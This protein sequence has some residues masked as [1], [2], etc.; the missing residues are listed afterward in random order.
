MNKVLR[1]SLMSFFCLFAAAPF[2]PA[3]ADNLLSGDTKYACEALM[4]LAT[5][6]RPSECEPSIKKYFM[7]T[8]SKPW[9]VIQARK[10][11]LKLCPSANSSSQMQSLVEAIGNGAGQCDVASIINM[12]TTI[13]YDY[14]GNQI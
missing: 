10:N 2:F 8:A 3:Q 6:Q 13:T 5:G 9:L 1:L 4:C 14:D 7:I 12:T 11:F